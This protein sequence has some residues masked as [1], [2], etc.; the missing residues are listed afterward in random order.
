[1]EEVGKDLAELRRRFFRDEVAAGNSPGCEILGPGAPNVDC[2]RELGLILARHEQSRA[3]DAE[4]SSAI[5]GLV[6][7]VEMKAGAVVGAHR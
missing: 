3:R 2:I 5:F 7:A 4:S 6:L 1:M